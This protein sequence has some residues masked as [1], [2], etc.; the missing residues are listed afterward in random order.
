MEIR[1]LNTSMDAYMALFTTGPPVKAAIKRELVE[2]MTDT[3]DLKESIIHVVM[4]RPIMDAREQVLKR[5]IKKMPNG[6]TLHCF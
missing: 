1:F 2:T 5:T 6:K 4:K 3:D